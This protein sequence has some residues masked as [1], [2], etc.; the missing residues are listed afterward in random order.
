MSE[1]NLVLEYVT[2]RHN[3]DSGDKPVAIVHWVDD[4]EI[5]DCLQE[6]IQRRRIAGMDELVTV[7]DLVISARDD[8]TTVAD[9]INED[10]GG[11]DR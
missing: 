10:Y 1:V 2:E 4:F 9:Y 6:I 11:F 7:T 8:N 3:I 5:Q